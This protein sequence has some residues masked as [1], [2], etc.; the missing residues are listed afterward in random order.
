M[1]ASFTYPE[2]ISPCGANPAPSNLANAGGTFSVSPAA[3]IDPATGELDLTTTASGTVY[4]I[5]YQLADACQSTAVQQ[6]VVED[7]VPPTIL[8]KNISIRLDSMKM[9][10]I[11]ATEL[12]SMSSDDCGTVSLSISQNTFTQSDLGLNIVTLIVTDEAGN[13]DSCMAEVFVEPTTSIKDLNAP[14]L[15]LVVYPNPVEDVLAIK[16]DSP[17]NGD[18]SVEIF[19][20][21][22]QIVQRKQET[23]FGNLMELSLRLGNLPDG[24]YI[25]QMTQNGH[26]QHARVFKK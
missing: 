8:C 11:T 4:T 10:V 3:T 13:T 6:I 1:D 14:N 2:S 26:A 16:W 9:A 7:T 22:G 23:K 25:V 24:M 19:N 5:S 21:M 15:S 18:V 12:D 17:W 20:S